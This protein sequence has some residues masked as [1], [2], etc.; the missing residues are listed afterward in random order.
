MT[1]E[2]LSCSTREGESGVIWEKPFGSYEILR[3]DWRRK[4]EEERGG[5]ER[6]LVD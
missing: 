5:G 2:R 6:K 4:S 3:R 1:V